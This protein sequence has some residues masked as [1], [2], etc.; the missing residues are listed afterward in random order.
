MSGSVLYL[1][2]FNSVRINSAVGLVGVVIP[3]SM[4]HY[5]KHKDKRSILIILGVLSNLI[6]GAIHTFKISYNQWFNFND[7]SHIIMIFCFYILY[8]GAKQNENIEMAKKLSKA[9][10]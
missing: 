2:N 1:N 5:L 10:A 9:P 8:K 6:P 7:I 4:L 3:V